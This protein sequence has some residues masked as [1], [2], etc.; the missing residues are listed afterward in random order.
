M[1]KHEW[2]EESGKNEGK[3]LEMREENV[4]FAEVKTISDG[5]NR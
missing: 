3:F 4:N 2:N 5:Y 1:I